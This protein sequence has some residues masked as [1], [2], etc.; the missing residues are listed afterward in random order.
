VSAGIETGTEV[1]MVRRYWLI[2]SEP[3]KYAWEEL[4]EDGSTYWDGVRNHEARNNLGEMKLG[5]LCLYYHSNEGKEVVGVARVCG[6]SY[7]DPTAEDPRWLVVDV[8]P[9]VSLGRPVTL[10]EIKADSALRNINL[11]RRSR[12]S[13]VPIERAEFDHILKLGETKL[14]RQPARKKAAREKRARA[15]KG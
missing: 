1:E 6:E 11:I 13:V 14:P 5:D 3:F 8:E 12:L 4:V 15:I 10:R 2:K 9:V 7:P